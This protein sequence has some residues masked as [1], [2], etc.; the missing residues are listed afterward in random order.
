MPTY[1]RYG[2][3]EMVA[4][5]VDTEQGPPLL[6]TPGPQPLNDTFQKTM[7]VLARNLKDISED[8]VVAFYSK[9]GWLHGG[10]W[11]TWV[12]C[13]LCA[14]KP[15]KVYFPEWALEFCLFPWCPFS[16]VSKVCKDLD[17][18]WSLFSLYSSETS[19]KL[20][21]QE[22]VGVAELKLCQ[23]YSRKRKNQVPNI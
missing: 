10:Y 7:S 15:D 16:Q 23:K 14:H 22:K 9:R 11:T 6:W 18:G 2:R 8:W 12:I 5:Q 1:G 3:M 4:R 20:C 17:L 13:N 19:R 21:H